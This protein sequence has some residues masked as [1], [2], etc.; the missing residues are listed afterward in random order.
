VTEKEQQEENRIIQ[1]SEGA[2]LNIRPIPTLRSVL[3][4]GFNNSANSP[5]SLN[6]FGQYFLHNIAQQ[7][8]AGDAAE[9][10]TQGEGNEGNDPA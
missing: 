10:T 3:Y 2:I 8:P 1:S 9:T 7:Q 6:A 4:E 5:L